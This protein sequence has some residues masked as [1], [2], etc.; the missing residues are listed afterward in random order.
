MEIPENVLEALEEVRAGGETNMLA[1]GVV[2]SL[3]TDEEAE[4]WLIQNKDRYMEALKA[5]GERR[6]H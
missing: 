6:S 5:M 2:I 4:V 3:V 1:R